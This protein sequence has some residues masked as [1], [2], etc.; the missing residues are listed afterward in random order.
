M[1]TLTVTIEFVTEG[2]YTATITKPSDKDPSRK[3]M[4]CQAS[5]A[6]KHRSVHKVMNGYGLVDWAFLNFRALKDQKPVAL[7]WNDTTT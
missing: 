1:P 7:T 6:E 3:V 2:C 4:L 5:A